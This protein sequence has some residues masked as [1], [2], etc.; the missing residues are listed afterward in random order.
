MAEGTNAPE[1]S[2]SASPEPPPTPA[3]EQE[4]G[5]AV[6]VPSKKVCSSKQPGSSSYSVC[7]GRRRGILAVQQGAHAMIEMCSPTA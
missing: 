2:K 3:S 1:G 7:T 5:L 6:A 4:P